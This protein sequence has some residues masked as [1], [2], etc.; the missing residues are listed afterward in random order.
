MLAAALAALVLPAPA[1]TA[2]T[3]RLQRPCAGLVAGP[4]RSVTR[5]I[6]AETVALDDGS[7]LRL[8]GALAPRAIDSG[9]EPGRWPPEIAAKAELS[10][11]VLGKS[12]ELA[13]GGV[14]TDRYG[15]WQAHAFW[16]EEDANRWV[17]GYLLEQGLARAY[18]QA[19]NR[20]C[21]QELL[22]REA[23]AREARRGIWSEA[24]YQ[25]RSAH[26]PAELSHY[27]HTF[28]VV[29][30]RVARVGQG[31]G[32]VYLNFDADWRRAFSAS[33]GRADLALLGSYA[34]QPSMLENR[35]VRVRGW[36]E[37]RTGLVIDLS[38]AGQIEVL[39]A[40]DVASDAFAK[41]AN[42]REP[43]QQALPP[44]PDE[45]KP[46]SIVDTGR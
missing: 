33:L 39:D 26:K 1:V 45:A 8:I 27:L 9:A 6:D 44:A 19:G 43:R 5:I 16:A 3:V 18:T 15:R 24:A 14:R 13:F 28:Q 30:G 11:L 41:R 34:R 21:A 35:S 20:V 38:V 37:Q 17:Q 36:I 10:A 12:I 25:V 40:A 4:T 7:E 31:R 46:P 23:I 42:P 29:E 32:A 22:V 2:Q